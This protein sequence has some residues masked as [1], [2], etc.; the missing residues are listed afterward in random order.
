MNNKIKAA[1]FMIISIATGSIIDSFAKLLSGRIPSEEIIF[2]RYIFAC[3]TI[4]PLL[5]SNKYKDG[6]KTKRLQVHFIRG[7]L[8]GLGTFLWVTG[9][10]TTMLAT[11]TL[12]G[13]ANHLFFIGLAFLFLRENVS[14]KSW[15]CTI[16]SFL[17]LFFVID[18]NELSWTS[19]TVILLGGSFFFALLDIINKKY[20]SEESFIA[21]LFFSEFFAAIFLCVPVV[22]HFVYPN[23]FEILLFICYGLGSN[24]LVFMSLKA[25]TLAEAHFLTPFRFFGFIS[26]LI[27]GFLFFGEIPPL[28]NY[29]SLA[30]IL[31]CN[32]YL[33]VS[34][35]K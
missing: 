11:T 2:G 25:F 33:L 16:I 3:L 5:F 26:S 9:L 15:I 31:T 19:G 13:F 23:W 27:F 29:I 34:E 4:L 28:N 18:I 24:F 32:I 7:T 20:A 6:F 14:L 12:V 35:K 8:V 22:K 21:M 30:I 1:L 10:K 17:S